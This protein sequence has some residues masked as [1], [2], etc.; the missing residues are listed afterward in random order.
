MHVVNRVVAIMCRTG[1]AQAGRLVARVPGLQT[2][3][4]APDVLSGSGALH[5]S[6]CFA[7]RFSTQALLL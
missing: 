7:I 4:A 6:G 2:P 3:V 5:L 1:L